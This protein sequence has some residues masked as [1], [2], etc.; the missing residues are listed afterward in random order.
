M[1]ELAVDP[2]WSTQKAPPPPCPRGIA[3]VAVLTCGPCLVWVEAVLAF[4]RRV[5]WGEACSRDRTGGVSLGTGEQVNHQRGAVAPV[6][7]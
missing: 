3:G 5:A 6:A 2:G 7:S 4:I 1:R